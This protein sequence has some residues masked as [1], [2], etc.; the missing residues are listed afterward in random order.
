VGADVNDDATN[1]QQRLDALVELNPELHYHLCHD[2]PKRIL[3]LDG[4]GVLGVMELAFL[5]QIER[6]LRERFDEPRFVLS[7]YFD[8]IGG[9]S[10]GAIIATGLSLGMTVD[11]IKSFYFDLTSE[12]FHRPRFSI[13]GIEPKFDARILMNKLR[14]ILGERQLQS[15]DLK[16]GL[17]IV[18]K[19]VDTGS[20]WVLTNN[21][22][23]KFWDDN[24]GYI[25]NKGY[26]LSEVVR[27]STA[28]PYYYS[29][30]EIEIVKGEP[31]GLFVDGGVTPH[32]NPALQMLML[33]SIKGYGFRWPVSS[34][35]LLLI[36]VGCGWIRPRIN[37]ARFWNRF[38][39]PMAL[40]TLQSVIWDSQVNTLKILQW[41]SE[42]RRPWPINSEV[43]TLE[44]EFLGLKFG[45]NQELL[46]FQRYD[47]LLDNN[48]EHQHRFG[49]DV[50]NETRER[51][52][53]FMD[54]SIMDEAYELARKCAAIQ[55]DPD[56]FPSRF[57]S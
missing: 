15:R 14:G 42:P 10:T 17:A 52:S 23:A 16:T 43:G 37:R 40:K 25:G 33:A 21:P 55:V 54:P 51:L 50:T 13:P 4:G 18:L 5:E 27:A 53:D 32:N 3:A 22:A 24:P 46:K 34:D 41:I 12:I 49:P 36:S 28:A 9:T 31:K 48:S 8:L 44:N 1:R 6:I 19:R 56:D 2:H 39:A 57:D 47:V 35:D 11:E 45:D 7:D 30:K 38:T 26:K 29:P 20:P